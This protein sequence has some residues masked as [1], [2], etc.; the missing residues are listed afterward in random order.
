MYQIKALPS[1]ILA[2]H[3]IA[4]NILEVIEAVASIKKASALINDNHPQYGSC[5]TFCIFPK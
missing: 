3:P 1:E 5:V 2:I 4:R